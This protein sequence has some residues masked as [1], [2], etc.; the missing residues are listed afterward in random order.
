[1]RQLS[2]LRASLEGAA[3]SSGAEAFDENQ[4]GGASFV[5][6]TT[7]YWVQTKDVLKVRPVALLSLRL[8][9]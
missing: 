9:G 6:K 2:D 4:K 3:V 7:K 5:R 1:V 8:R